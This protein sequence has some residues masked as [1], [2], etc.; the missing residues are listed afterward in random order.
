MLLLKEAVAINPA[1]IEAQIRLGTII[2]FFEKELGV[3]S[4]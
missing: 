1:N 4:K 3:P 2:L